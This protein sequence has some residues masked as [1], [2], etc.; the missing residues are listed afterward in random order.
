MFVLL[1]R[2]GEW[3]VYFNKLEYGIQE[4]NEIS[5]EELLAEYHRQIYVYCY[6]ILRNAHDAEEAVQEVFLKAYESNK[7]REIDNHNAWLYKIAYNHCINK[8]RRNALIEFIPFTEKRPQKEIQYEL[9]ED[10]ELDYILSKLT[11]KE[12]AIIV[13]RVIEDKDFADIA[14]I[15]NISASAARK[16]F[17]RVKLKIQKII[18]RRVENEGED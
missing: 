5:V 11:A 10:L 7:I 8:V 3:G 13:L 4:M 15:L 1:N 12:R 9:H 18:E 6:N 17:E 2:G 14:T 16:R